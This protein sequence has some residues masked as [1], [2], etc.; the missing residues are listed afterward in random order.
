MK[1]LYTD[2][3][4]PQDHIEQPFDFTPSQLKQL[5]DNGHDT[6]EVTEALNDQPEWLLAMGGIN[7]VSEIVSIKAAVLVVHICPPLHITRHY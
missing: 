4:M 3:V 5:D 7:E 2:E 6:E 1:N